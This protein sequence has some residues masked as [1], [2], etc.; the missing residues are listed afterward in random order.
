MSYRIPKRIIQTGKQ[1]EQPLP[2]R[3]FMA[4]VRLLNPD[5]EYLFFDDGR[6][7]EFIA[8]EFPQYRDVFESFKVPIQRYDFFRYL[9]IYRYGGFYLDLDV[10][11]G[12]SLSTLLEKGCVFPFERLTFS[13]RLRADFGMDWEI[14]NY[15]FG[16]AAGHP[17][18]KAIIEN[19]IRGQR[20]P[21]WVKS[22]MRGTPPLD[23]QLYS[24]L[25][26]DRP[27]PLLS[28]PR[29]KP[30]AGEDRHRALSG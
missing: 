3:A 21:L 19:C 27:R 29:R 17:F 30:R 18:L 14:G 5:Y 22:M 25:V 13:R 2:I 20:D 16:A 11:L 4:N 28:Y 8:Q 10:L 6:V 1:S 15:A 9:A 12:S 26:F 24:V 7:E 23:K